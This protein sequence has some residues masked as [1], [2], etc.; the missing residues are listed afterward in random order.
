MWQSDVTSKKELDFG[1]RPIL[2]DLEQ[3][4]P[5][6]Q[7]SGFFSSLK[8]GFIKFAKLEHQADFIIDLFHAPPELGFLL[9]AGF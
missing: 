5:V 3:G 7:A 4:H 9:F 2:A 1:G 8:Y 6:S